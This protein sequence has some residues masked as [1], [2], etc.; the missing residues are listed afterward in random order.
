MLTGVTLFFA[1]KYEGKSVLMVTDALGLPLGFDVLDKVSSPCSTDL[2]EGDSVEDTR[3]FYNIVT[4]LQRCMDAPMGEGLP[5]QPRRLK[6]NDETL[7]R[8]LHHMLKKGEEMLDEELCPRALRLCEPPDQMGPSAVS[9]HWPQINYC[10]NCK[11]RSFPS[12]LQECPRCKAVFFCG[13]C[14]LSDAKHW[15]AK[16][17]RHMKQGARL[18]ELPFSFTAGT[19]VFPKNQTLFS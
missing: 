15:C 4:L 18:A 14:F 6:V 10:Q 11:R 2:A 13:E 7:H 1:E 5:R 17:S 9:L 19:L 16:L 12:R 8:L 3:T